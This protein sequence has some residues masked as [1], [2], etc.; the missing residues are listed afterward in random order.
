[1]RCSL[2]VEQAIV[3]ESEHVEQSVLDIAEAFQ[4]GDKQKTLSFFSPFAD[5]ER[6]FIKRVLTVTSY[7]K[8]CE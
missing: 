8:V 2:L 6:A 5:K 7:K 4:A 1:M 3:T